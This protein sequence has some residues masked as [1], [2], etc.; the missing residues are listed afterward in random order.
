MGKGS[1]PKHKHQDSELMGQTETF[2][3]N[4]GLEEPWDDEDSRRRDEPTPPQN[5]ERKRKKKKKRK[6]ETDD[7]GKTRSSKRNSGSEKK[8]RKKKKKKKRKRSKEK[9]RWKQDNKQA[10][11]PVSKAFKAEKNR[12]ILEDRC[13]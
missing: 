4:V 5:K 12:N 10:M 13:F 7:H 11:S 8:R 3:Q 6:K 1:Q 2:A 9:A